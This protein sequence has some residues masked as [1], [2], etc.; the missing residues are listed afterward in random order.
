MESSSSTFQNQESSALLHASSA[1]Y[2][3]TGLNWP[4]SQELFCRNAFNQVDPLP[5]FEDL[6][7]GFVTALNGFPSELAS[8]G[9]VLSGK[10]DKSHW[11]NI[12]EKLNIEKAIYCCGLNRKVRDLEK[13]VS[14]QQQRE[15]P[16]A[17]GVVGVVGS[18][19]E[20]KTT[21]V[22][23][24][25]ERKRS[26]YGKS[27]ILYN[28]STSD[29][30]I[31]LSELLKGLNELDL[32]EEGLTESDLQVQDLEAGECLFEKHVSSQSLVILDNVDNWDQLG[33][34]LRVL[35]VLPPDSLI[36]ITSLDKDLLNSS[37]VEDS[38]I[39]KLNGLQEQDGRQLFCLHAFSRHRAPPGFEHLV[40][41]FVKACNG[42][43]LTLKVF[44]ALLCGKEESYWL[45]QLGELQRSSDKIQK[46]LEISYDTL[47][48]EEQTMFL[49][50]A[51]LRTPV[52]KGLIASLRDGSG[53]TGLSEIEN[54]QKRCLVE[55][56]SKG[57]IIM[58]EHFRKLGSTIAGETG[59]PRPLRPPTEKNPEFREMQG[60]MI[61]ILIIMMAMMVWSMGL[62]II[63]LTMI[64]LMMIWRMGQGS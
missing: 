47:T 46:I 58:H 37:G 12:L 1:S 61:M 26:F 15:H 53:S 38:S 7:D 62:T 3:P 44:G 23:E 29:P 49:S 40:D 54:L 10:L 16:Q 5:D 20:G 32:Q 59:W 63:L 50:I 2:S 33:Q 31:L 9:R 51:R 35:A 45:K 27:Y 4:Q 60:F 36:L 22:K 21:L 52:K 42:F 55:V 13:K 19:G 28:V 24:F 34:L 8:Y 11:E 56:D 39:Y 30:F 6:V 41:E 14:L 64:T 17:V 18:S 48:T 57:L 43:P 25:F